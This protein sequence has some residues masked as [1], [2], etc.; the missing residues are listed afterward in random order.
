MIDRRRLIGSGLAAAAVAAMPRG[1]LAQ[2]IKPSFKL[3]DT[4]AH[5]YTN[6]VD[7]YPFKATRSRYGPEVMVAKAMRF[8]QT[9]KE[10]FEFWDECSIAKGCGVQY[11]STYQTDNRYLLDI[12]A[13]HPDRIIP[14]VITDPVAKDG[15]ALLQKFAKENRIS[16]VRWTSSPDRT[17]GTYVFLTD[18]AAPSWEAA[19]ALGLA[20]VLMPIGGNIANVMATVAQFAKKYPRVNIVLDHIGFP[21]PPELPATQGLTPQ[22]VA[23]AS[24]PNVYYKYTT[25]LI[26]QFQHQNVD[27]KKFVEYMVKTFSAEKMVWGSDVGNTPGS[28]FGWVQYALDSAS[29]LSQA[30]QKALFFDTAERVFIPGG[31]PA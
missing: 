16:G 4:H 24:L 17:T 7:K 23:L 6:D 13:E 31:R 15:P 18:A 1:A 11:N 12:A 5:F 20:V 9:P 29:G 22:H 21:R 14:V 25:L 8:P 27:L 19:N 28:M 30:Q 26:E 10:V 2:V 3:F